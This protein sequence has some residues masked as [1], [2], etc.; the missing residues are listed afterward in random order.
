VADPI[1]GETSAETVTASSVERTRAQV[2]AGDVRVITVQYQEAPVL[3]TPEKDG[4]FA[5]DSKEREMLSYEDM[6][7][8]ERWLGQ[9]FIP[10]RIS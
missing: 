1:S 4:W 5:T 10:A 7:C 2:A 3:A 9:C 8:V 6:G